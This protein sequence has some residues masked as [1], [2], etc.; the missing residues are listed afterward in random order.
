[1]FSTT[2]TE[3]IEQEEKKSAARETAEQ[4]KAESDIIFN[5]TQLKALKNNVAYQWLWEQVKNEIQASSE[6]LFSRV[7]SDL[8]VDKIVSDRVVGASVSGYIMGLGFTEKKIKSI[9]EQ[10]DRIIKEREELKINENENE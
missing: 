1:M 2:R 7:E 4:E 10:A 5:A 8:T 6:R 3:R 9:I